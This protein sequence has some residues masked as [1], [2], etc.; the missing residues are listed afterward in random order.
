MD[1]ILFTALIADLATE[2]RSKRN[3]NEHQ[4]LLSPE[5]NKKSNENNI[6]VPDAI[7]NIDEVDLRKKN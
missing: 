7:E 5:S 1:S 6:D 3:T 4:R 2:L